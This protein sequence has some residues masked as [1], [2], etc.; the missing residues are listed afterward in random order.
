MPRPMFAAMTATK[1]TGE[2]A[3]QTGSPLTLSSHGQRL[4]IARF[5][6][7]DE[8]LDFAYARRRESTRL[9]FAPG[10]EI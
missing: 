7:A 10:A 1:I 2:T 6:S 9:R 5:L 8:R 4:A 3:A